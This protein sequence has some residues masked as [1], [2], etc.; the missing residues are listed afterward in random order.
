M[1]TAIKMPATNAKAMFRVRGFIGH[2]FRD[3]AK[4]A[5]YGEPVEKYDTL[6]TIQECTLQ[7]VID[8]LAE[9]FKANKGE[10]PLSDYWGDFQFN[11]CEELGRIDIQVMERQAFRRVKPS[12]ADKEMWKAGEIDLW[13][14]CYTFYVEKVERNINLLEQANN[15]C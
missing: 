7:G 13:L 15:V 14:T 12:P 1:Q 9:D 6:Y 3:S 10:G 2:S 5:E 11:A 8:T 4:S